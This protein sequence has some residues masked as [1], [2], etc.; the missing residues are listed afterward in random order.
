MSQASPRAVRLGLVRKNALARGMYA[1][2]A[3]RI[4]ERSTICEGK[5]RLCC[6]FS[7]DE[8]SFFVVIIKFTE[9]FNCFIFCFE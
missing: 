1:S 6:L 2:H 8:L 4:L 3:A 7:R 9:L 5:L